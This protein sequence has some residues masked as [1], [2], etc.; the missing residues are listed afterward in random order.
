MSDLPSE[1]TL[2]VLLLAS[3]APVAADCL[4]ARS[5]FESALYAAES[6]IRDET[7]VSDRY[8][9]AHSEAEAA[10]LRLDREEKRSRRPSTDRSDATALCRYLYDDRGAVRACEDRAEAAYDRARDAR[11]YAAD[12][13]RYAEVAERRAR[14]T[15]RDSE[16][17]VSRAENAVRDARRRVRQEC[18][19]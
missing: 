8:I 10:R 16:R 11:R 4:S 18:R 5:A 14:S 17:V 2:L 6:A 12:V 7:T 15:L 9:E 13:V 19:L 1:L 3:V